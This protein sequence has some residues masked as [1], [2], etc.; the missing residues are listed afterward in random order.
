MAICRTTLRQIAP[1]HVSPARVLAAL[2]RA[3]AGDM[4]EGM[5]I[6]MTYAVI[7]S[8]SNTLVFARAGHE[9][10]LLSRRDPVTGAFVSD[11]VVSEGMPLGLVDPELFESVIEDKSVE[12]AAG[13]TLVLYTDGLTEAP[14]AEE[15]EF[16]T[17]RLADSLRA[18][19]AG[20]AKHINEAILAA[21]QHFAGGTDLRD[22]YTLLTVKRT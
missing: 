8:A 21:V 4:R 5:Y 7:D 16:G 15:K 22:D 1:H 11:F 3:V 17:G 19:H 13:S 20:P 14:N 18:A 12:F 9:R 6:T 10:P 2:N